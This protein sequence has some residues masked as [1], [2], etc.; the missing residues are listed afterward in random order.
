MGSW[1]FWLTHFAYPILPKPDS[2]SGWIPSGQINF[3]TATAEMTD[4]TADNSK[5]KTNFFWEKFTLFS[6][7]MSETEYREVA[8]DNPTVKIVFSSEQL[9]RLTW[10]FMENIVDQ[11]SRNILKIE[12]TDSGPLV[13]TTNYNN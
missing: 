3:E 9:I 1:L 4:M 13:P 6:I 8:P 11:G 10:S 5:W 2:F 12:N 7:D